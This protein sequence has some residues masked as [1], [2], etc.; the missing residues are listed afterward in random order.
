MA[1][2]WP[3]TSKIVVLFSNIPE[4]DK[5]RYIV[6]EM[7]IDNPGDITNSN[8]TNNGR[9]SLKNYEQY[10]DYGQ[11]GNWDIIKHCCQG[12]EVDDDN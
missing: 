9:S 10:I 1:W 4:L 12:I 7:P 3:F 8:N 6:T 5:I 2:W 11:L